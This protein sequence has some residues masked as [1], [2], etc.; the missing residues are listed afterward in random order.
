MQA[1]LPASNDT[2]AFLG[3]AVG[4][5]GDADNSNTPPQVGAAL[6][7]LEFE[8]NFIYSELSAWVLTQY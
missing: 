3:T 5:E 7:Y 1:P 4:S 8:N 2:L 6:P